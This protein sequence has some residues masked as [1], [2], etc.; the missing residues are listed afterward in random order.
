[1]KGDKKLPAFFASLQSYF[2][3]MKRQPSQLKYYAA[4]QVPG[5]EVMFADER[6]AAA[7]VWKQGPDLRVLVTDDARERSILREVDA[8]SELALKELEAEGKNTDSHYSK[9]YNI[10]E[11][12]RFESYA[13]YELLNGQLG[14]PTTQP[15]GAEYIP[16]VD[17]VA[18][19]STF[20]QWAAKAPGFE[21]RADEGGLYKITGGKS[22]RIRIGNYSLP[23]VTANGRW[24]IATKSDTD[25]GMQLVR[26]NLLSNREYKIGSNEYPLQ[27]A[28]AY[29]AG[30]NMVLA[31]GF[32]EEDHH[33]EYDESYNESAYDNGLGYYFI[34]PDTGAVYPA[35]GEVRPLAQQTFRGLQPIGIPGEFWAAMPRGKAGTMVGIYSTRNFSFK[36]LLKLPKIIFDSTEM[37]VDAAES[38]FYFIH[39]GH[40]LR[41]NLPALP[42]VAPPRRVSRRGSE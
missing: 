13:W 15:T 4:E 41:A 23:V 27:K 5:L 19:S 31:A 20:G 30:R 16:P 22:V 38:K 7:T 35:T 24:A 28:I 33:G 10:R 18:P 36:P 6:L 14:S 11:T 42:A 1:V 29:V 17:T 32:E 39:E 8:E 34:N 9:F 2:D 26:I 40:L 12:R 3:E 21:I 25:G 37:W